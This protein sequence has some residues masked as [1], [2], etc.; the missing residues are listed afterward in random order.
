MP[1]V[2]LGA[3]VLDAPGHMC[4]FFHNRDDEYRVLLPF[5][6][7]GFEQEWALAGGVSIDRLAEY[8]ADAKAHHQPVLRQ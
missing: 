4:A 5:I 2:R 8:E 7:E 3:S 6:Q 1:Y